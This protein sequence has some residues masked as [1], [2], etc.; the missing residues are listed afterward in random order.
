MFELWL[1]GLAAAIFVA[2]G[3]V[4][5]TVGVGLPT[6]AVA[7]LSQAVDAKLAIAL[8]VVPSFVTNTWQAIRSG[9]VL[10]AMRRYAPFILCLMAVIGAVSALI[11][12]RLSSDSLVAVLGIAIVVF[13]VSNLAWRPPALGDRWDRPAQIAA[14]SLSGLMGGLTAIW[15]PPMA[16]Y[17]LARRVPKDEFVRASGVIITLGNLPLLAG[18]L[19]SGMLTGPIAGVSALMILPALLGFSIGEAI[20]HRLDQERFRKAVLIFFLLMGLNLLRRAL[21]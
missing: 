18:F 19:W 4:K 16:A 13:A 17:L 8:V 5:G 11:T 10:E 14:G 12:A 21:S 9:A 7:L 3:T 1:I 15:A 20:R 2:A 6:A